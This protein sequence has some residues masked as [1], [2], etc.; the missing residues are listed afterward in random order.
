MGRCQ[1]DGSYCHQLPYARWPLNG[2]P[3]ATTRPYYC[4]GC[5]GYNN[6]LPCLPTWTAATGLCP[7]NLDLR[8]QSHQQGSRRLRNARKFPMIQMVFDILNN[9]VTPHQSSHAMSFAPMPSRFNVHFKS[10]VHFHHCLRFPSGIP[11]PCKPGR[12]PNP[13]G[14]P[15]LFAKA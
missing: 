14:K 10:D 2:I 8:K 11:P 3:A 4:A 7:A 15:G 9:A 1:C 12:P 5:A 6:C 13:P